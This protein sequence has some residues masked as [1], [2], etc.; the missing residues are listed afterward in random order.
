MPHHVAR[1]EPAAAFHYRPGWQDGEEPRAPGPAAGRSRSP[2]PKATSSASCPRNQ[3]D[4]EPR[5]DSRTAS[6]NPCAYEVPWYRTSSSGWL[7]AG[8][9]AAGDVAAGDIGLLTAGAGPRQR[10]CGDRPGG[11]ALQPGWPGLL[12]VAPAVVPGEHARGA[13]DGHRVA[14]VGGVPPPGCAVGSHPDAAVTAVLHT[15]APQTAGALVQVLAAVGDLHVVVDDLVVV[16]RLARLDVRRGHPDRVV[17]AHGEVNAGGGVEVVTDGVVAAHSAADRDL[18]GERPVG[19]EASLVGPQV[20]LDHVRIADRE[21]AAQVAPAPQ[22]RPAGDAGQVRGEQHM[23]VG[24]PVVLRT[25]DN[26]AV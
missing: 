5:P 1:P 3:P 10:G 23:L 15:Q 11:A 20:D 4:P 8:D 19:V 9:L 25:E 13:G 22:A 7:G 14:P 2:I 24:R 21:R 12:P 17:A 18:P 26:L 6:V 16:P